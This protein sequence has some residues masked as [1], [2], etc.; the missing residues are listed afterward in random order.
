MKKMFALQA[1]RQ[2]RKDTILEINLV[3]L[4]KP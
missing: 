4:A 1:T 2:G 3:G